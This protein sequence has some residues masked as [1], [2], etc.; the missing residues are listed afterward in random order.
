MRWLLS[1]TVTE[2][3][4]VISISKALHSS[5]GHEARSRAQGERTRATQ[6]SAKNVTVLRSGLACATSN[7]GP[8]RYSCATA[9]ERV[10]RRRRSTDETTASASFFSCVTFAKQQARPPSAP[11]GALPGRN[12]GGDDVDGRLD[13]HRPGGRAVGPASRPQ[14]MQQ[15]RL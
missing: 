9:D 12:G 6:H 10:G 3:G 15:R 11:R 2:P 7:P 8:S 5:K 13:G 4:R 1:H 14:A